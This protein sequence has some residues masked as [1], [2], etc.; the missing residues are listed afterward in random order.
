MTSTI[1]TGANGEI[2]YSSLN[3]IIMG[4][5]FLLSF[6]LLI[7]R[8]KNVY[9]TLSLCMGI[10]LL[11]QLVLLGTGLVGVEAGR[12]LTITHDL[13]NTVSFVLANLGVYQMFGE[14]TKKVT[15]TVYGLLAG[16]VLFSIFPII[17]SVYALLMVGFAFMAVSPLI[18]R[19]GTYRVGLLLYAIAS[20]AHLL[21]EGIFSGNI[22]ALLVM[23]NLFR[24]AFFAAL[25]VILFDN[26]LNILESNYN[27]ST[28]DA[29]TG[30]YNRF[31][32]YTTVSYLMSEH[33]P[34][35]V[36]FF[37]LDNFKKINDSRGHLEGDKAL[38]AV[39]S[40][41]KE[42]AEEVG[43]AGRYGGEEM[44]V[45]VEDPEVNMKELAEKIRARIEDETIVTASIGYATND[46][47]V[48]TDELIK[49]ADKA[50]YVAKKTG[51]NRVIC[52]AELT[53]EQRE[54]VL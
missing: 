36:I 38:R 3:I 37:D 27:K 46:E 21:N 31:Y 19:S 52:F 47:G 24:I 1:F 48:S 8:Q 35:S 15:V 45:M 4:L 51:K 44:V 54:I 2:Y 6:R 53:A 30:L 7:H 11:G 49:N 40:I 32:F 18:D 26:V 13:L 33:K 29:L 39:A 50:M 10:M 20:I 5:L 43:I 23:D 34:I 12:G 22:T 17:D 25:F 14:T 16:A 42:E 28:R 9:L 41:L